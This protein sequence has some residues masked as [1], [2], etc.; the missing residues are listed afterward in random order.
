MHTPTASAKTKSSESPKAL[1]ESA[2]ATTAGSPTSSE[3]SLVHDAPPDYFAPNLQDLMLTDITS[4]VLKNE[5]SKELNVSYLHL[6]DTIPEVGTTVYGSIHGVN[7]RLLVNLV[8]RRRRR[9]G[10]P[11]AEYS[12][13]NIIF[14][15]NTGSPVTYICAEAMEALIGPAAAATNPLPNSLHVA[16]QNGKYIT[17][18]HLSPAESKFSNVNVLGMD[19]MI[20]AELKLNGP[21]KFFSIDGI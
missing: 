2:T 12:S 18:C 8:C 20:R 19:V 9:P 15:V 11:K 5:V 6:V 21:Q 14:L 7:H 4:H 1:V 16:L 13:Y 3:D 17:E 10:S